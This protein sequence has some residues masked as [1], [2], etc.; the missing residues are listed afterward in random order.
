MDKI[1]FNKSRMY[2]SVD[3]VLDDNSTIVAA[4]DD[5]SAAHHK[6]KEK[7]LVIDQNRQVQIDNTSGM[8]ITKGVL[9]TNLTTRVLQFSAVVEAYATSIKDETLKKRAHYVSS[10]L[11]KRPD[12][13]LYD[14][15]LYLLQ[16]ANPIRTDVA[17]YSVGDNEFKEM[18][19][20]LEEFRLTIPLRRVATSNS[21]VST[22]NI[23]DEF[24]ATDQ[25]LKEVM[26]SLMR[27]FNFTHPDFFNAYTNA[28]KIVNYKGGGKKKPASPKTAKQPDSTTDSPEQ[29]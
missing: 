12:S 27:P 8:T 11:N 13:Y 18:E 25:L 10:D 22:L 14:V 20:L 29:E 16:R 5:L 23:G 21:K 6:L 19:R 15:G 1:Q 26:D 2:G 17:K 9:R 28:R 24:S 3:T 4:F 7:R